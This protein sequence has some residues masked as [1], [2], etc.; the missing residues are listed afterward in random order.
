MAQAREVVPVMDPTTTPKRAKVAAPSMA[1]GAMTGK[2]L[3]GV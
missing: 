2:G 3:G 1:G